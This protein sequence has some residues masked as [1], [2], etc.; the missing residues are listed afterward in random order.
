MKKLIFA[1]LV[2]AFSSG[3][4]AQDK[5][6]TRIARITI[7]SAQLNEYMKLL[8]VQMETAVHSEPGVL[9]YT[10]YSDKS[11]ACKIT[12]VEVYADNEAYLSHRETEHFKKYKDA[13]KD[14]VKSLELSEVNP[15]LAIKKDGSL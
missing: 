9:S 14:M 8:K 10:V 7:D 6:I 12:L 1:A 5:K 15:V 4:S 2:L 13:T 3:L 11:D